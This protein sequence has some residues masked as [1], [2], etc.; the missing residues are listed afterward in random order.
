MPPERLENLY[1]EHAAG[2]FRYARSILANEQ[3]AKD[4]LQEV[5]VKVARSGMPEVE[6]EKAWLYRLA[7]NGAVDQLRRSST[8][9]DYDRARREDAGTLPPGNPVC[10]PDRAEMG[11]QLEAAVARLPLEQQSVVRL[12]LWQE[13]TFQ[14]IAAVQG[15]P[16]NTAA[17]RYRY[18]VATLRD[19][20]KPLYEE[21][22]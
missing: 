2:L 4:V 19:Q 15:I 17:S 13:L 21:L 22:K 11:R 5:F 18:A 10:D 20:L 12:R 6:S 7:H 8:R 14:E 3:A 1:D 16:L 9:R